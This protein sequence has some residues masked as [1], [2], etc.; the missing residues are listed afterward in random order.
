[1]KWEDAPVEPVRMDTRDWV[2][3]I[4]WSATLWAFVLLFN[5]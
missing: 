5:L 1:M 4:T 3:L 2:G